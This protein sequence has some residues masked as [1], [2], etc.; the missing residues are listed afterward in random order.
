M[1]EWIF[2]ARGVRR[3]LHLLGLASVGRRVHLGRLEAD[4]AG[5]LE[6]IHDGELLGQHRDEHGLL[7]GAGGGGDG[8]GCRPAT[9]AAA[10]APAAV[11][12]NVR[13]VVWVMG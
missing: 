4:L 13:R 6:A 7:R 9:P 10:T 1:I 2:E 3:G 5:E 8:L 12:R 11:W